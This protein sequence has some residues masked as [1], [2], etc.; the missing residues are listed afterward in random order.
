[1]S[2]T[3]P[4]I[5]VSHYQGQVDWAQVKN[6]GIAFA[7]A[8]ATQSTDYVDPNF[9]TNW[10]GMGAAG[11]LRGAYHFFDVSA[12]PVAQAEHFLSVAKPGPGDLPPVIDIEEKP[13]DPSATMAA[14]HTCLETLKQRVGVDPFIY[15]SEGY[16]NSYFDDSFG[17]YPLWV[18]EYGVS[19][20]KHVNGWGYWTIWQHSQTGKVPG[21]SGNVDLDTF[22]GGLDQLERFQIPG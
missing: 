4:G 21:I 14:L 1:M 13:S 15:T 19:Q 22:N 10:Q 8:K 2:S 11:V 7:F 3:V 12:D 18:A 20:P 6:S 5:D 17:A 9:E 16:W